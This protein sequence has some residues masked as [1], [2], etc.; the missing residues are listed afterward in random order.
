MAAPSSY[1]RHAEWSK[2]RYNELILNYRGHRIPSIP[3]TLYNP[4]FAKFKDRTISI[5][6]TT[7]DCVAVA[8]LLNDMSEAYNVEYLRNQKF[9]QWATHYLGRPVNKLALP[10]QSQEADIG[11]LYVKEE[12]QYAL[13]IGEA[14]NEIGEG[15]GCPYMQASA[16]YA[17]FVGVNP[18]AR[19]R[20][21]L[22]PVFLIYFAG[23]VLGIGGAV[24]GHTFI[25]QPLT[26]WFNLLPLTFDNNTLIDVA[27]AFR[28]LKNSLKDLQEY[29]DNLEQPTIA[30]IHLQQPRPESYPYPSF[31][32]DSDGVEI[33]FKYQCQ[34]VKNKLLFLVTDTYNDQ[35]YYVVKFVKK[36]GVDAHHY[37]ASKSIAPKLIAVQKLHDSWNMIVMEYLPQDKF[38][39]VYNALKNNSNHDCNDWY[40][41]AKEVVSQMHEE[42]FVH[43]DLRVSNLMVS[44]ENK[45]LIVDFDWANKEGYA[46]YPYFMNRAEE[47]NWHNDVQDG[48][49][50]RKEHDVYFLK[51][52]FDNIF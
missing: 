43:G 41:K 26:H 52:S 12:M 47:L 7:E 3:I 13:L 29:Y 15:S 50:I 9:C 33:A 34:L 35:Q 37:C 4:V 46:T 14:K 49:I 6:V 24:F 2:G 40:E 27:R 25:A 44:K 20:Y 19:L 39:C 30:D 17:K 22:N 16:S 11:I 21:H 1:S 51:K 36:Y 28:A 5:K 42:N 23:P 18:E 38:T 10:Q 48:G 32:V 8:E 31:F 45:I